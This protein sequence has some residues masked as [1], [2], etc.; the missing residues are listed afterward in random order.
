MYSLD[1]QRNH[2]ISNLKVSFFATIEECNHYRIKYGGRINYI[3]EFESNTVCNKNNGY[4]DPLDEGICCDDEDAPA[5]NYSVEFITSETGSKSYILT[6]SERTPLINGFRYIKEYL[7]QY[8]NM[9]M[10][11]S[12]NKLRKTAQM[13]V[14]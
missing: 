11:D 3:E 6:V 13:Y 14:Q 8:H 12:Y 10:H 1:Y 2:I 9:V 4:V 7:I 5:T